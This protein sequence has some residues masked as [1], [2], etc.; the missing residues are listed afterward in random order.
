MRQSRWVDKEEIVEQELKQLMAEKK[1]HD[2][3]M[4]K[5]S[6]SKMFPRE[7][8]MVEKA[9][10]NLENTINRLLERSQDRIDDNYECSLREKSKHS[11]RKFKAMRESKMIERPSSNAF[12][13]LKLSQSKFSGTQK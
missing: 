6:S 9:G 4:K 8:R 11:P 5:L 1:K 7:K 10:K 13:S 2:K 3:D 12:D